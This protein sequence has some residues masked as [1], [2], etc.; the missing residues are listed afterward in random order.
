MKIYHTCEYCHRVHKTSEI[1][2]PEGI[3]ELYELC[4]ECAQEIGLMPGQIQG[5]PHFYN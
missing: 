4:Q 1:E 2:G 5:K 3:A